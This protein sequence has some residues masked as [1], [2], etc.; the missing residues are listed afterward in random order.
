MLLYLDLQ[1]SLAKKIDSC[2]TML[3]DVST[4]FK[5]LNFI[6]KRQIVA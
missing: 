5:F 4:L 1:T 2:L 3:A 6:K